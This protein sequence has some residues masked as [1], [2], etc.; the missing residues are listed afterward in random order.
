MISSLLAEFRKP[1][2]DTQLAALALV[3]RGE[4]DADAEKQM[5]CHRVSGRRQQSG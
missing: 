1:W 3:T 5:D 2:S 4:E